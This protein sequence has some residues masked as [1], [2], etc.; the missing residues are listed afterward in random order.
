[1]ACGS[2]YT[3]RVACFVISPLFIGGL[4]Y[5]LGRKSRV[6]FINLLH[7]PYLPK[8]SLIGCYQVPDFLWLFALINLLSLIW[9]TNTTAFIT[10]TLAVVLLALLSEFAQRSKLISGAFDWLDIIS[11]GLAFGSAVTLHFKTSKTH[12]A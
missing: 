4:I 2:A 6:L 12:I 10:W 9:H 11:Y 8:A 5:L 1:M 3:L 7:L